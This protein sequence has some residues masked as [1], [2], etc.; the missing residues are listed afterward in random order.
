[1]ASAAVPE[2]K[3][4]SLPE[5]NGVI[6]PEAKNTFDESLSYEASK[7]PSLNALRMKYPTEV[8]SDLQLGGN[9][10]ADTQDQVVG[11]ALNQASN[12]G[13]VDSFSGRGLVAQDIGQTAETLR[14]QRMDR[15]H[16]YLS[17]EPLEYLGLTSGQMASVFVDDKVRAYQNEKDKLQA[18]Q[19]ANASNTSTAM[20]LL[21]LLGQLI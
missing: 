15:A 17:G 11:A 10:R 18:Q 13:I 14:G 20:G 16:Q 9:L 3:R 1:M 7:Q 4:T 21:G 6:I 5:L 12:S 19:A 8:K 2:Y